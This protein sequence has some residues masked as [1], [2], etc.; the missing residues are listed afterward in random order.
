MSTSGLLV[1]K[2]TFPVT[3]GVSTS[4]VSVGF[5]PKAVLA[6][7]TRQSEYGSAPGNFGGIGFWSPT[8]AAAVAWGSAAD[9][10][11]IQSA[12][13]AD[14]TALLGLRADLAHVSLR[15][16]LHETADGL[17]VRHDLEPDERWLV[18]LLALGGGSVHDTAVT[19]VDERR[20][21]LG[22]DTLV[23]RA[24]SGAAP[25]GE[26]ERGHTIAFGA[27]AGGKACSAAMAASNGDAPGA[28]S[29]WQ[30]SRVLHPAATG[31][32]NGN[33]EATTPGAIA[34]LTVDGCRARVGTLTSPRAPGSG[35][36]RLGFAPAALVLFSWGFPADARVRSIGRLS[37]GAV[38]GQQR[39]AASWDDANVASPLTVSH[40]HSSDEA[41]LLVPDTVGGGLHASAG[42][43]AFDDRGFGLAWPRS[44]GKRRQ[45]GFAALAAKPHAGRRP[46]YRR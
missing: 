35:R 43:A 24:G 22:A 38:T 21:P 26:I 1:A 17:D 9:S 4:A 29:G 15:G 23:F 40:V 42:D 6:W 7:W 28:V 5:R 19:W 11:T 44:D 18:H 32:H 20:D 46:W 3:A 34:S 2:R 25:G 27:G 16:T 30:R 39:G 36:T 10:P 37:L 41:A 31:R 12:E 13:V 33:G 45:V 14:E 8:S